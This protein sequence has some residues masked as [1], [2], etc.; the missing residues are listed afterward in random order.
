MFYKI[1]NGK[2]EET[3]SWQQPG[4]LSESDPS[5]SAILL[6]DIKSEMIRKLGDIA[7]HKIETGSIVFNTKTYS[8]SNKMALRL[9]GLFNLSGVGKGPSQ[10][11]LMDKTG[12]RNILTPAEL[13][14]LGSG[15][16]IYQDDVSSSLE[17]KI[18]AVKEMTKT[19]LDVFDPEAGWP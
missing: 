4:F 6:A 13:E 7:E 8:T 16:A 14:D 15:I 11:K 19:Q 9:N 18:T 5:V 3:S 10:K 17:A 2:I 12:V 1:L